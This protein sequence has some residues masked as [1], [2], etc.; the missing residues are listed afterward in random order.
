MHFSD[1]NSQIAD[2]KN[3]NL[4]TMEGPPSAIAGLFIASHVNFAADFNWTHVD[5]ASPAF[6]NDRATGFG[7]TFIC[8]LLSK[9][10]D[11]NVAK[12]S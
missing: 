4:G 12:Q 7:P 8:A 11:A 2:M 6:T 5:I 9:H 3:S 1:L 10:L